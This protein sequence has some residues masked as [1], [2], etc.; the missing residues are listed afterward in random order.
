MREW[1]MRDGFTLIELVIAI[2]ILAILATVAIPLFQ[3][4]TKQ[5]KDSA[6]KGT[7]AAMREAIQ[8]YR[9]NEITSGR[10]PGTPN[11][12]PANGCPNE[13]VEGS[14]QWI[15]PYTMQ[16]GLVPDNPWARGVVTAGRENFV[17]VII[18]GSFNQRGTVFIPPDTGW[19]YDRRTCEIWAN[20]A[21]NDG[22]PSV[23][24]ENN[25]AADPTTENCF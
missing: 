18:S 2:T 8:H 21:E 9:M 24:L 13:A 20:T 19:S 5:A 22:T 11:D 17:N 25:C 1:V 23:N 6:V 14:E 12:W 10:Q 4:I 7:V 3:N 15:G 16:D